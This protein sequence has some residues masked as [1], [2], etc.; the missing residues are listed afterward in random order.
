[1]KSLKSNGNIILS[2]DESKMTIETDHYSI[3][4]IHYFF[5]QL[6]AHEIIDYVEPA[7]QINLEI[8]QREIIDATQLRLDTFAQA[9]GYDGI[10]SA[11][12]YVTSQV[13]RFSQDAQIAVISRDATWAKLYEVLTEAETGQRP[14]PTGFADIESELPVLT[15]S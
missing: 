14:I 1:M 4:G 5:A 10:L 12:T 2:F 3:E 11:C 6:G 8:L 15:W 7:P 9:R 13:P